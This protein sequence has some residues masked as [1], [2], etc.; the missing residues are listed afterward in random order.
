MPDTTTLPPPSAAL[1]QPETMRANERALADDIANER[2]AL[3]ATPVNIQLEITNDCNLACPTCARNYWD[4]KLNPVGHLPVEHVERLRPFLERAARVT[5]FGYGESMLSPVFP[6]ILE[7]VRSINPHANLTLFSNGVSLNEARAQALFDYRVDRLFFSIDAAD[8]AQF[9]ALRTASLERFRRNIALVRALRDARGL[10]HPVLSG[11]FTATR[12]NIDQ[13]I[14]VVRFCAEAGMVSL[15]VIIAR[16]FEV[17]QRSDSLY[18]SP[19]DQ[20]LADRT[21]A[22]AKALGAQLGVE[23]NAAVDPAAKPRLS[24]TQPFDTLFVKW[25]GDVR[26]CCASAIFTRKPIYISVGNLNDGPLEELWNS[27]YARQV[28]Q[29]FYDPEQMNPICRACPFHTMTLDTL[30]KYE[31]M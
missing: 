29:G 20:A 11:S 31:A 9:R 23:V 14:P 27:A 4:A 16:V 22:D 6:Q 24:C 18:A 25:N 1:S 7:R 15:V 30:S 5:T 17:S 8:A 26:L 19:E 10:N 3:T 28:R 12:M 13:L 2:T 21:I